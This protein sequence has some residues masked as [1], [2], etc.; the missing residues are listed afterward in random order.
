MC[1]CAVCESRVLAKLF[2]VALLGLLLG[3]PDRAGRAIQPGWHEDVLV[4]PQFVP[5]GVGP[6][7][8]APAGLEDLEHAETVRSLVLV[9]VVA[10][11]LAVGSS[12][13][14]SE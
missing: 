10:L 4:K 3:L 1:C 6:E 2:P 13:L 9:A 7:F 14:R 8:R 12:S 11:G 5:A